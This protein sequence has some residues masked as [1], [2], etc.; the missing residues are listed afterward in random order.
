MEA[1]VEAGERRPFMNY[2]HENFSGNRGSMNRD[3]LNALFIY[4]INRY[5]K[6]NV[7]L[8]PIH[9]TESGEGLA[10]ARFRALV[11]GGPNW[12]PESGQLYDVETGWALQGSDWLLVSAS[13]KAVPLEEI[14]DG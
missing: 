13:W 6:L 12:L 2:V 8:F 5:Q 9:V 10:E 11:T 4:Q 14:I 7:Q 1:R 3:G